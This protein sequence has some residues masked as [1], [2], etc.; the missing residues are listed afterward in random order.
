MSAWNFGG[1]LLS[2]LFGFGSNILTNYYNKKMQDEANK[3]NIQIV[4]ET[5]QANRDMTAATNLANR[6]M[7]RE[8]NAAAAAEAEK[9]YQR[10][11]PTTQVGNMQAAGMSLAGAINNLNGGGSYSPA[12][13]NTARD[14]ASR[15]SPAQVSPAQ[16]MSAE[17][18][19]ANIA[20][21]FMQREQMKSSERM[22]K[23]QIAAQKEENAAN[24]EN[25]KEIAR[26][27]AEASK[28]GADSSAGAAKYGADKNFESAAA[29]LE[30]D[31]AVHDFFKDKRNELLEKQ[32]KSYVDDHKES[33]QQREYFETIK[34]FLKEKAEEDVKLIRQQIQRAKD[35]SDIEYKEFLLDKI[36]TSISAK[37]GVKLDELRKSI[38]FWSQDRGTWSYTLGYSGVN[39]KLRGLRDT[40]EDFLNYLVEIDK[41]LNEL[42]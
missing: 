19:F 41:M 21:S 28:Y 29:R 5:N 23:M 15:D 22:A 40:E 36:R 25:A 16:M 8:Q 20:Q 18:V 6:E 31:K 10:S 17:G 13:V 3:T 42:E 38:D 39:K 12:P 32:I 37:F 30:F 2:S 11:K 1:S 26:I 9:A 27:Q 35:Q 4:R 33:T 7:V 24:R 34:P 14:E